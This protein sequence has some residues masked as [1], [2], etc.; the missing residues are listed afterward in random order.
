MI[1]TSGS[2]GRP[3][4]VVVPHAGLPNLAEAQVP[5]FGVRPGDRILLFAPAGLRH[6]GVRDR[7]G[8]ARRG[9]ALRRPGRTT[10]SPARACRGCVRER[11]I[12]RLTLTPSALALLPEEDLPGLRR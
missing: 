6:L 9:D 8:P 4:G 2:T 7:D 10:C 3:K 12:T 11:G 1:F 5:I